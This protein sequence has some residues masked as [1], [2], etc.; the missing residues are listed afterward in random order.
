MVFVLVRGSRKVIP[1]E[2]VGS[3]VIFQKVFIRQFTEK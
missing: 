1:E 2:L 3:Y